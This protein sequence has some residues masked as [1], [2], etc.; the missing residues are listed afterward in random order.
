LYD[1][2]S[3]GGPTNPACNQYNGA[4]IVASLGFPQ[5]GVIRP[6]MA[7]LGFAIVFYILAGL[8]LQWWQ[9]EMKISL[10]Q[11]TTTDNSAGKEKMTARSNHEVRTVTIR[12]DQYALDIEKSFIL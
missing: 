5:N 1:C 8:V 3:P 7:L 12:L 2:P 10:A 9:T 6:I 4:Y 11:I